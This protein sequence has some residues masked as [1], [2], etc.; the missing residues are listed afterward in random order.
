MNAHAGAAAEAAGARL[1]EYSAR[2]QPRR[3]KNWDKHVENLERLCDTPAFRT[4]RDRILELAD[5]DPSDRVLDVGAGTGLLALAASPSVATVTAL[6]VSP[7][8]CGHLEAKLEGLETTN[9]RVLTDSATDLPLRDETIDVA[10]SNY[11]F[12]HLTDAEKMAALIEIRRVLRGGGRL[13]IGDMMFGL[14][15]AERR[16]R[17]V[18]VGVV[19]RML[20]RGPSGIGRLLRNAARIFTGRGEHPA[21]PGWWR[22]ALCEVGFVDVS[23][24]TLA[25]EGGIAVARRP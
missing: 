8:M 2:T 13:V 16:D 14:S 17:A 15:L 18:L 4:L 24:S 21:R 10:L 22:A 11:C 9:V 6:D 5:L 19:K 23:V 3:A 20:A 1:P 12:H 7:A 25:H